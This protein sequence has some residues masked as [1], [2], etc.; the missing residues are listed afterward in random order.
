MNTTLAHVLTN[1]ARMM[2]TVLIYSRIISVCAQA[3]QTEN[4]AR[5]LPRDASEAR[6][7]MEESARTLVQASTVPAPQTT[8]ALAANMSTTLA[9]LE[10]ARME[11]HVW[12]KGKAI[13]AY[14]HQDF[15]ARI[16]RMILWI[17]R[18]TLAR[19]R[20]SVSIYRADST[21]SVRSI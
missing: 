17:V 5:L 16:V 8:R 6:V 10:N 4:N 19:H 12:T 21:A 11:Q 2:P 14:A 7:S 3:V 15:R 18:T 1:H 20:L 13:R 9:N